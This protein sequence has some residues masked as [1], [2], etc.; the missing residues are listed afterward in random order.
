M[1][2]LNASDRSALI[3]LLAAQ[4]ILQTYRGRRQI[5]EMAGLQAVIPQID[6][7]GPTLV[8]VGELIQVLEAYGRLSYDHEALGLFLNTMKETI[9]EADSTQSLI[10]ELLARYDLMVP[11]KTITTPNRNW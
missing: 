3:R 9:G 10:D 2:S 11:I 1:V 7:E 8:A 4:P 6:L 5:L